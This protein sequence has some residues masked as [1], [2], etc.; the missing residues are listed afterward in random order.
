MSVSEGGL[1]AYDL[2]VQAESGHR[3]PPHTH[4]HT[5]QPITAMSAGLCTVSGL[6]GAPGRVG[7]SMCDIACGMYSYGAVLEGLMIAQAPAT[8]QSLCL[9]APGYEGYRGGLQD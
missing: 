3:I 2:L 9:H 1:Q 8:S 5:G 6:P 4:T 7:V